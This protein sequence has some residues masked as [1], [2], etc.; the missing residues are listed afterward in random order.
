[1][2]KILLL[3]VVCISVAAC[4]GLVKNKNGSEF[5]TRLDKEPISCTFLYKIQ[6]DVSVYNIEDARRF[7]ENSIV[8]KTVSGNAY[9]IT[10]QTTK[11]NDWVFFGPERSFILNANVYDCP[12]L[13]KIPKQEK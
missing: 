13:Q 8:E 4:G 10:S 9:W 1:M 6:T 5:L 3:S 12:H 2:R 11:Q 7:L